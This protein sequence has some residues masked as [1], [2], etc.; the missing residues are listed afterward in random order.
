VI[1][2]SKKT[3]KNEIRRVFNENLKDNNHKTPLKTQIRKFINYETTPKYPRL[4]IKIKC[5]PPNPKNNNFFSQNMDSK[6]N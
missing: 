4:L 3:Q 2:F 1:F 6:K 5:E